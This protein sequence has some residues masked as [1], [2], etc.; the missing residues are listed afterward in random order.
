MHDALIGALRGADA[1]HAWGF[2]PHGAGRNFSRSEHRRRMGE[3]TPQ[4]QLKA[5]TKGLD[6]RFHAGSVDASELPSSYKSAASVVEQ[7]KDY[8]LA[9]IDDYIDPYGCIMAGDVPPFW[10]ERKKGRR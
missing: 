10:R 1:S 8:G 4:E 3:V 6:V 9:K 2:S 7:I 5:E